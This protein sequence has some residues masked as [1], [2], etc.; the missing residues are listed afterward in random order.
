MAAKS[1]KKREAQEGAL[2]RIE[3]SRQTKQSVLL[4]MRKAVDH[5]KKGEWGPAAIA[6]A[7]AADADAKFASAYHLLALALDNLG[8]R[9][10]AFEM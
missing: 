9:H 4:S 5:Y 3:A 6:A 8:Q 1:P 7:E 2:A 10:K